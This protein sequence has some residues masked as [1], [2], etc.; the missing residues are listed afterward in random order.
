M[1]EKVKKLS[2][3]C[4]MCN[5]NA[6]FTF[7]KTSSEEIEVIGGENIYM[8]LCR[9]CYLGETDALTMCSDSTNSNEK[10]KSSI[11]DDSCTISSEGTNTPPKNSTN[12][13]VVVEMV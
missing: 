6:S 1:A 11:N 10:G 2:A 7:R 9:M 3:V 12:K 4:R 5:L 8:P 13:A